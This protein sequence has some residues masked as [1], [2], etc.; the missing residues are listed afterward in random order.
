MTRMIP[1][2]LLTTALCLPIGSTAFAQAETAC[3]DLGTALDS[4]LPDSLAVEVKRISDVQSAGDLVACEVELIAITDLRAREADTDA[5]VAKD[6]A[7]LT[8]T[9]Q[10][11]VTLEDELTVQGLVYLDRQPAN[12][13]I[14]GGETEVTVSNTQPDVTV[15]EGEANI[16]I[17][18]APANVTIEMPQPTIRIEQRAPEII[19]TMPAPGVDIANARPQVE[20][21]QAEPIVTVMQAAPVVALELQ[22]VPDGEVAQNQVTDRVTGKIYAAG[23]TS[24]AAVLD[25]A[26][27]NMAQTEPRVIYQEEEARPATVIRTEPR[28]SFESAE[29]NVQVT[30]QGEPQ[31]EMVQTGEPVVTFNEAV[32][33]ES[34][35][36]QAAPAQAAPLPET[37]AAAETTDA[38][39]MDAPT[40]D[41]VPM[42]D[43]GAAAIDGEVAATDSQAAMPSDAEGTMAGDLATETEAAGPTIERDGY[44]AVDF[45]EIQPEALQG[46]SVYGAN[47]ENV[48]NVD[49]VIVTPEGALDGIVIEVGG[50]LGLGQTRVRVPANMT[51]ILSDEAGDVRI[52]VDATEESLKNMEPY[53][54]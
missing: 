40:G 22:R 46:L 25:D 18:Q 23:E 7:T 2:L 49:Q 9:D 10:L 53:T 32:D 5:A 39:N 37:D 6:G 27:I 15:T 43:D 20:V 28:I 30:T 29:P 12:V 41:L 19:I 34:D 45:A 52:Y 38:A 50:F 8:E 36:A 35:D 11:T 4:G 1:K 21:R 47:D 31:I 33:A 16:L 17:R 13:D 14:E 42:T 51:T 48:S 44:L 26:T 54:D 24:E 3:V